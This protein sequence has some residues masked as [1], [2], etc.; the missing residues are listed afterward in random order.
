[1]LAL[2][3]LIEKNS[4]QESTLQSIIKKILKETLESDHEIYWKVAAD[5]IYTCHCANIINDE[6]K[7]IIL[8]LI[9]NI[10]DYFSDETKSSLIYSAIKYL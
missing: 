10:P 6:L 3:S 7:N 2:L 9:D 1:M 8:D 5:I 4:H